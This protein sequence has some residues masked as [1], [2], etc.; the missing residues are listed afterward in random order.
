MNLGRFP[1]FHCDVRGIM[2]S[3]PNDPEWDWCFLNWARWNMNYVSRIIQIGWRRPDTTS[4]LVF[5]L[6]SEVARNI[7]NLWPEVVFKKSEW[8]L[9]I[10]KSS[11]RT[12][13]LSDSWIPSISGTILWGAFHRAAR[14]ATRTRGAARLGSLRLGCFVVVVGGVFEYP[15]IPYTIIS[16][17][18]MVDDN[19]WW[20]FLR[21]WLLGGFHKWG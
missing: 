12:P 7:P 21:S 16:W 6:E 14:Q 1:W 15:I 20:W 8:G 4:H 18:D 2:G 19:G 5:C 11:V 10:L 17:D 13:S 3:P 9:P